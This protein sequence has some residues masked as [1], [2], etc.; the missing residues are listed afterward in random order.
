M[1]IFLSRESHALHRASSFLV[2]PS[3][4]LPQEAALGSNV[5]T[6][7][8]FLAI[9]ADLHP[10]AH[11]LW[12]VLYTCNIFL[13]P[14]ING[15]RS[16]RGHLLAQ[17]DALLKHRAWSWLAEPKSLLQ[18]VGGLSNDSP[19]ASHRIQGLDGM[20]TV[21]SWRR[22]AWA[23]LSLPWRTRKT[24]G[25]LVAV[26]GAAAPHGA[27][28]DRS[29][30]DRIFRQS[31]DGERPSLSERRPKPTLFISLLTRCRKA[32]YGLPDRLHQPRGPPR[33][34]PDPGEDRSQAKASI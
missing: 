4:F 14:E 17:T 7:R 28:R 3:P 20:Q 10:S 33:V 26:L 19:L 2:V 11:F 18:S 27:P 31:A 5:E 12:S 9:C 8:A 24:L 32:R 6:L 16:G 25:C 34:H 21:C 13:H 23:S 30:R 22:G 1:A 15:S 29:W